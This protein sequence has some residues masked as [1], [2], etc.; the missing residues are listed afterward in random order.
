MNRSLLIPLLLIACSADE[1]SKVSEAPMLRLTP[2][3]YH[4]TVRDLFGVAIDPVALPPDIAIEGFEGQEEGQIA[5]NYLVERYQEA[6]THFSGLALQSPYFFICEDWEDMEDQARA[7]CAWKSLQVFASRAWRAPLDADELTRLNT[8]FSDTLAAHGHESAVRLTVQAILQSPRFLFRMEPSDTD[9]ASGW[10][11]ASRLSYTLWDT[12]PDPELFAA[13][14]AGQL[15]TPEQVEAQARRMLA[16]PR[17][18]QAVV[19]FHEQWLGLD[20]VHLNNADRTTYFPLY[21]T[22]GNL[23]FGEEHDFLEQDAEEEWAISLIAMRRS[24]ELEAQL[25]VEEQI[26]D[27]PGTLAALLTS[28]DGYASSHTEGIYGGRS[29][30]EGPLRRSLNTDDGNLSYQVTV[31]PTSWDPTQRAGV[32][33]L[34]AVLAGN[35]HPV[36]P[37]PVLRGKWVLERLAC[38]ALGQPPDEAAGALPPDVPEAEGTNRSRLES[39]TSNGSCAVCHERINPPGFALENYD[40]L[41]GHRT[42]DNGQPIDASGA[43]DLRGGESLRF[44]S[45]VELAAQLATSAQVH[46]CYARQWA[47]YALGRPVYGEEPSVAAIQ[48][49]F[50][51]SG[52]V[53]SLLVDLVTSD[54]FLARTQETK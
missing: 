22:D 24:M 50:R 35:A 54:L 9:A 36:H 37:A 6:A 51:D 41:G 11:I 17:A 43:L 49:R 34:P 23:D 19:R 52:D 26:F 33:T 4:N 7:D 25:F 8:L 46:D 16:D 10:H 32:L 1:A 5:S 13:A 31:E 48:Q 47:T 45:A 53:Q 2:S 30:R 20:K 12:M 14:S 18:R 42:V 28:T 29:T 15:E 39:V 3:E 40:S 27:G 21:G 44:D 38:E